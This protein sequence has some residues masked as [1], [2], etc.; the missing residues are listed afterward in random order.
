MRANFRSLKAIWPTQPKPLPA[1]LGIAEHL[2]DIADDDDAR[3]PGS[4]HDHLESRCKGA[5]VPESPDELAHISSATKSEHDPRP[6]SSSPHPQQACTT[7]ISGVAGNMS[8][9][10]DPRV[11]V[12]SRIVA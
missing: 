1:S 12:A 3:H 10:Q 2:A 11:A 4:E 9:S 5:L 6:S 7:K 8:T